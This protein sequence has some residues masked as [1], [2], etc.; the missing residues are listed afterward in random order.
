MRSF[1]NFLNENE[2]LEASKKQAYQGLRYD[3]EKV[4]MLIDKEISRPRTVDGKLVYTSER[5][6]GK[7]EGRRTKESRDLTW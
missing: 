3:S 6:P 4:S 1:F 7:E 2:R 5:G